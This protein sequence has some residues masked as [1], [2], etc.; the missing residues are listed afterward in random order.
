MPELPSARAGVLRA[1]MLF[2]VVALAVLAPC[3]VAWADPDPQ[4][5]IGLNVQDLLRNDGRFPDA[6]IRADLAAMAADGLRSG[7]SEARWSDVES[8]SPTASGEHRYDWSA[9]DQTAAY[10][11]AAGVRWLPV[12]H[13]A[14]PWASIDPQSWVAAPTPAHDADFAAFAGAFAQRYAAGGT[15]WAA[16]PELPAL[17]V[18]ALEIF[19]EENTA[20]HWGG[21]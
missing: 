19:N 6:T 5:G 8:A 11:A 17:P 15:F 18:R 3:A 16:H 14:P 20:E 9:T 2:S 13:G 21:T 1:A 4:E 10:L 12:L 7:R